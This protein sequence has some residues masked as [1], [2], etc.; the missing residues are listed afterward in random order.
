MA[1]SNSYLDIMA[2]DAKKVK[3]I[4]LK[5]KKNTPENEP[6]FM[7]QNAMTTLPTN[8][9]VHKGIPVLRITSRCVWKNR[10]ITL[11]SD[12]QAFFITHSKLPNSLRAQ[13]ASSLPRPFFTLSKGFRRSNETVRHLDVADIDA[14]QVGVI[15]TMR[16]EGAKAMAENQV[17]NI[18]TIFH[19]GCKSISFQVNDKKNCDA[20]IEALKNGK[21]RYN[22]MS[23][24][25]ANDQLLLRYIYYDIDV[26]KSGTV[27]SK[28][29][30]QICKRVNLTPPSN[31]E[32]T[33]VKFANSSN[34]LTIQQA[35]ELLQLVAIGESLM[36]DEKLWD[37]L[38]GKVKEVEPKKLLKHFFH[39]CQGESNACNDDAE[40]FVSSL[41]SLGYS[42]NSKMIS[43]SEFI[44][45]L[46]S[47]YNDAYDPAAIVELPS[48]TKLD[49]PLCSYWINT[50]HNTYLIGDQLKSRSSVE[51]YVN[52]LNRGCKCLELDCWDG[53]AENVTEECVP[54]IFHGHT[55]TSK[56]R[57]KAVCLVVQNYL[58]ANPNTYPIILSL[59]NH[60]SHPFQ[61]VI[62]NNMKE[63]FGKKLFIPTKE[64]C[65]GEDIPSPEKL[66]GMVIIKGKRPPEADEGADKNAIQNTGEQDYD[67]G[68][69]SDDGEETK[70]KKPKAKIVSELANLTLLHGAHFKD[71]NSSIA[72]RPSYMHSIGE[73]KIT[74]LVTQ[75]EENATLWREYNQHHMTR[76]YPAG[77][78]VDSSN[79]NP[80]LAWAMGCQLVAL[81]FQTSDSSLTLND[82]L[83]RQA[84]GCG[85]I[86]KPKSLMGGPKSSKKVVKISVLSARCLP[87]PNGAKTGEVIDPF[88]QIDLHDV[89]VP[90]TGTENTEEH[91]KESFKTSTVNNNGL[92][93]VWN[94]ASTKFEIHNPDVAMIHFRII[95]QDVGS[96]DKLCSSAIP[97]TCLRQGYRNI[98][99]YDHNN[100]RTGHFECSTL[101][102][103]IEY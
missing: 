39:G 58:K 57:F 63:I 36:P 8:S 64:Q 92:C 67:D 6:A 49:L 103:K 73:T 12:K 82:G 37:D 94:D 60:C 17:H 51:A 97:V 52:A 69:G 71:F 38:F 53:D 62:A 11:S 84:G 81:N 74:K 42:N 86:A 56:I 10:V 59:E 24:W 77:T 43:K 18:L 83:F 25:I 96:D 46:H 26:D 29:F 47:K 20:L 23:P 91:T 32:K 75:S 79:Y 13:V 44:H 61:T 100:T 102:V 35:R 65:S 76:T 85:Y 21:I 72:Q 34:D 16:L 3:T 87:K 30:R 41:K 27:S 1:T 22:L 28:E 9:N 2:E 31:L 5:S 66:R 19:H 33:F 45:F 98:Q 4:M 40:L 50:S 14:W 89:R 99:L 48:S 78:R 70:S 101:F 90:D 15:G 93:P 80:V 68:F 55:L 88:I 7:L 95:D 54:V